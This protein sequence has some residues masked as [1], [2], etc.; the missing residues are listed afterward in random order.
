ME[1]EKKI[2]QYHDICVS[3]GLVFNNAKGY[4]MNVAN[5]RKLNQGI[6]TMHPS[7][8]PNTVLIC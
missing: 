1:M 3:I 7:T 8:L 5:K 4:N 6:S 2:P